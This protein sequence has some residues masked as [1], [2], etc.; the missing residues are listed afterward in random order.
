MD[1]DKNYL[2]QE[3]IGKTLKHG[4]ITKFPPRKWTEKEIEWV[5]RLKDEGFTTKQIAIYTYRDPVGVSIKMKRLGKKDGVTYNEP[6]RED[7]YATNELYLNDL[8]PKSVLDLY[9]GDSFYTGKVPKL[10]TN[11]MSSEFDTTYSE[12]AEKLVCKLFYENAKFDLIDLDPFGSAY[13][14]FDLSIKMASK[15][16]IITLGEIGHKRWQRLDFVRFHYGI[17]SLEDFTTKNLVDYIIMLGKRNKKLL[18]PV[19]VKEYRNISRVYF[20]I[21]KFK[22]TEQWTKKI[23]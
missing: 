3:Y 16:L 4:G 7:K 12:K 10:V 23:D 2:P 9:S 20:K 6:H 17:T 13:E 22:T 1:E 5:L 14:C 8:K 11:D 21:E 15:G 19:F 18:T